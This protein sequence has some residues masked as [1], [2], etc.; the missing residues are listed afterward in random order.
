MRVRC[1]VFGAR[2]GYDSGSLACRRAGGKRESTCHTWSPSLIWSR[3][4]RRPAISASRRRATRSTRCSKRSSP[5]SRAASASPSSAPAHFCREKE[6]RGPGAAPPAAGRSRFAPRPSPPSPR[7]RASKK[8]STSKLLLRLRGLRFAAPCFFKH[9]KGWEGLAESAKH[10]SCHMDKP[11]I[12]SLDS[13]GVP[14]RWISWQQA[15]FYYAKNLVAWTLGD[16][17]FTRSEEHTSELQSRLHLVCRLLLEKKKQ[18]G[19]G[20][21]TEL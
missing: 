21:W 13:H 17:T 16:E 19:C 14:H 9:C 18:K 1:V 2:F 5:T 6:R 12:L 10:N 8:P 3:L 4:R 11:L 15:C 7:G 20:I